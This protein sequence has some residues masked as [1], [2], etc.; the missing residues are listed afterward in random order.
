MV[1]E[2]ERPAKSRGHKNKTTG[3]WMFWIGI[4]GSA[5]GFLMFY[6]T[7]FTMPDLDTPEDFP[8]IIAGI[9]FVLVSCPTAI[10]GVILYFVGRSQA[11]KQ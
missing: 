11:K 9:V 2:Q 1:N 10:V 8:I 5:L 4:T 3:I 6:G 7:L